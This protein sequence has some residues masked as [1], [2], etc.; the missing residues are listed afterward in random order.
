VD[1]ASRSDESRTGAH[2]A[3]IQSRDDR[4]GGVKPEDG[5]EL[6]DYVFAN[7]VGRRFGHVTMLRRV[8]QFAPGVTTHGF[9]STFRDWVG[10][11]TTFPREVAEAAIA[12]SVGDKAEQAYRR[13][14]ALAKRRTLMEAWGQFC[15]GADNVVSLQKARETG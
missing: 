8:W 10:D 15:A 5:P 11:R 6:R 9:R 12:H 4:T 13:G 2:R 7:A 14:T 1:R 3:P